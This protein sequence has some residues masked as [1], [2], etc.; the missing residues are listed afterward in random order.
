MA[1]MFDERPISRSRRGCL[2]TA[3]VVTVVLAV[4]GCS[5]GEDSARSTTTRP[6]RG[7][8]SATTVSRTHVT[9]TSTSV[10]APTTI[11]SPGQPPETSTPGTG[12]ST[13]PGP[14]RYRAF[15]A[16]VLELQERLGS[17]D[18]SAST[19][20]ERLDAAMRAFAQVTAIAP[21]EIRPDL[22]IV[23]AYV[24]QASS[25][26]ALEHVPTDDVGPALQRVM[27]WFGSNCGIAWQVG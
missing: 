17:L 12:T 16:K 6:D 13:I 10:V 23:S 15:C 5:S 14:A 25:A 19:A 24:G 4:V 11:E 7:G 8:R 20:S 18:P 2:A 9:S 21:E 26:D 27:I 1:R 22:E 3:M